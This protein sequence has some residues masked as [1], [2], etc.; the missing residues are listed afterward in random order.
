[1]LRRISVSAA[2]VVAVSQHLPR[3]LL[4]YSLFELFVSLPVCEPV[5]ACVSLYEPLI[6]GPTPHAALVWILAAHPLQACIVLSTYSIARFL[7]CAT[8]ACSKSG[9]RARVGGLCSAARWLSRPHMCRRCCPA[10]VP[11]LLCCV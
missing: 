11:G 8:L 10:T 2:R 1:M 3:T 5:W 9:K 4:H 7:T 6:G